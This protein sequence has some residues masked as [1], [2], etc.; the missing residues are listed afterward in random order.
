MKYRITSANPENGQIEVAYEKDGLT[1]GIYAIDVPIVE[2]VFLT[3]EPLDAEILQRAP[4]W[5]STRKDE[6]AKASGFENIV[7]MVTHAPAPRDEEAQ[8]NVEMWKQVEFE[9][10]IAKVLV[11]LGVLAA[12]PTTIQLT[13]L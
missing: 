8:E 13:R 10:K 2:G 3:G 5:I 9:Q 1:I 12:D 4:V 6:V 7:A 11:K